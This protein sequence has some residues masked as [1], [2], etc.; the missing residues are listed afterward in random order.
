MCCPP[1]GAS[2]WVTSRKLSSR[3]PTCRTCFLMISSNLQFTVAKFVQLSY[4]FLSSITASLN[5]RAPRTSVAGL[6]ATRR[7]D[8]SAA[9]NPDTCLQHRS[10]LLRWLPIG[11]GVRKPHPGSTFVHWN[12]FNVMLFNYLYILLSHLGAARLLRSSHLR[13]L[14][15]P[16]QVRAHQLDWSRRRR[17]LVHIQR[18]NLHHE[19]STEN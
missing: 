16:W 3:T 11:K 14:G 12:S 6:V 19:F 8:C 15:Q 7:V 4:S 2:S 13:A 5:L 9:R 18:I 1:T 10:R 17:L